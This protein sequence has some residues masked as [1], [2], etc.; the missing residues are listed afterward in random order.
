M[1]T[2]TTAYLTPL[3]TALATN[4]TTCT[5][6]R[7]QDEHIT[8]TTAST[9]PATIRVSETWFPYW[10]V[11]VDGHY[12]GRADQ[13]AHSGVMVI[14][15]PP[16]EHTISLL[17]HDPFRPLRYVSLVGGIMAVLYL[18][19]PATTLQRLL[20]QVVKRIRERDGM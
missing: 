7:A 14:Q 17:F 13:D 5:V 10:D 6:Q 12:D 1:S 2:N 3:G 16:G 19:L 8:L 4:A 15:A 11:Y 9:Q 18:I 20:E